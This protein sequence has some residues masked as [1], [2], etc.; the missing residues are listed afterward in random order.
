MET[1]S[2]KKQLQQEKHTQNNQ[3]D[4]PS[5][6]KIPFKNV[7]VSGRIAS[8]AT[9][10]ASALA[11]HLNWTLLDGGALFRKINKDLK[12]SIVDTEKRPDSFDI[13]YEERIKHMLKNEK[14]NVIQSHL[15]GFDAQNIPGVFKIRV[16]CTDKKGNDKTEIRIDR[17]A[18]RDS[19]SIEMAKKEIKEREK[20]NLTKFRRL[21]A[22]DDPSWVYWKKEY[23]DL[24]I[25]TFTADKDQALKQTLQAIK[26]FTEPEE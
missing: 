25:N 9:T 15:A 18:N 13:Q 6:E 26:G 21:Y 12:I 22:N 4:S 11:Q 19:I 10:L 16:I 8:G 24:T 5:H 14:N 7:T 23:Y 3:M 2:L 17:L 20:Q 1:D